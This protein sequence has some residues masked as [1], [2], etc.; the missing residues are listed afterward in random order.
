MKRAIYPLSADPITFGHIDIIT[1]AQKAF[2]EVVVAIGNNPAKKYLFS[3]EERTE[4][5]KQALANLPNVSVV[6]FKGMLSDYVYEQNIPFMIRG[7]RNSEDFNY[8]I[9]LHQVLQTQE[10]GIETLFLPCSQDKRH[11]S[12]GASKAL[13]LEQ[14]MTHQYVSL[15][16][17]KALENRLSKQQMIGVTGSI[18]AGKST[19]CKQ[20]VQDEIANGNEAHHIDLDLIGHAILEKRTEPL[21]VNLR[22]ELA[23]AFGLEILESRGFVDRKKLGLIVFKNPDKLSLLNKLLRTPILTLLRKTIHGLQGLILIEGALL[24]EAELTFLCNNEVV[25]LDIDPAVQFER[26]QKRGLNSEQIKRRVESQFTYAKKKV[27]LEAAI[28]KDGF[29]EVLRG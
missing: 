22:L 12:S 2:D 15:N 5:A 24:I 4:M 26:L 27:L 23:K 13:Q 25:L 20:R 28:Q 9:M 18:G 3:Q 6:S 8:E 16:V 21:Y 29:G 14:G 10:L 11:I 1:R 7:V 19:Y 17:K